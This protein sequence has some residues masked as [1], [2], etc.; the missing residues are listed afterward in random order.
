MTLAEAAAGTLHD[1]ESRRTALTDRRHGLVVEAGA[2]SGK[3]AILAGRVALLMADGMAPKN[4]A[5]ITFTELAAAELATRIREYVDDLAGGKVPITLA[6]AF[7]TGSPSQGQRD[8]LVTAREELDELTCS[9][10]HGFARELVRPYPVEAD[11][12]PGAGVLEPADQAL[13]FNEVFETWLREQ[14][15]EP[16]R[17]S[18]TAETQSP[19]AS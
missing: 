18:V 8:A 5:A 7:P 11:I 16:S 10:I 14:L 9:T 3:T 15:G 4:I 13:L 17:D 6:S 12:D 2:G 19:A 1:L